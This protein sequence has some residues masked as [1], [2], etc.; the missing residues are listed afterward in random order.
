[1]DMVGRG[2]WVVACA[3][4]LLVGCGESADDVSEDVPGDVE[5]SSGGGGGGSESD[6]VPCDVAPIV[7]ER[8]TLCHGSVPAGAPMS[9]M[10]LADFHSPAKSDASKK[11]YERASVLINATDGS[12]MPP[13][14]YP[15]LPQP[16]LDTLNEWL[17]GGATASG[18]TCA[19][20]DSAATGGGAGSGAAGSGGGIVTS[21]GE[22]MGGISEEPLEYDDPLLECYELRAHAAGDLAAPFGVSTQPDLYMN[23]EFAAPWDG[24]VYARS[25]R[26]I[27]DNVPV[28]HHW[29]LYKNEG[30]QQFSDG[31]VSTSFGAHPGGQL[32]HGWAPG[33]SDNYFDPDVGTE[34]PG[35]ATY[36]L[37]LHYN[38]TTGGMQPDATGVEIC[39]TPTMPTHVATISWLGTDLI[40]GA[41]AQGTCDPTSNERIHI[42]GANPHMHIHGSRMKVVLNRASGMQETLHD[43]PFDFNYQRGYSHDVW[44]EPGDTITTTCTYDAPVT[45]GEGTGDEM[46]YWFA[47]HYPRLALTNGNPVFSLIHGPNTCL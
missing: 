8:C 20:T 22:G 39:V 42:I 24:M 14:V 43:Q 18:K 31:Q 23:F 17:N 27:I 35:T 1:M 37:E 21:S 4:A 33:A 45:F 19:I 9:L 16:Q 11:V 44:V 13:V 26:S 10:T 32:V 30:G 36:T 46:C 38:N 5:P 40:N 12:R 29:L 41:Q 3:L 2:R 6:G 25:Y 15:A 28:V 7:S 34:M 47:M